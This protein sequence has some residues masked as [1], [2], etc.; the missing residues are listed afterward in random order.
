MAG[1]RRSRGRRREGDPQ[2]RNAGIQGLRICRSAYRRRNGGHHPPFRPRTPGRPAAPGQPRATAQRQGRAACSAA[3]RRRRAH[4]RAAHAAQTRPQTAP[5]QGPG[6]DSAER[7]RSR[8]GQGPVVSRGR[9]GRIFEAR[10]WFHTCEGQAHRLSLYPPSLQSFIIGSVRALVG[11]MRFVCLWR[12]VAAGM[13]CA[14]ALA[15]G[16]QDSEFNVNNQYT[17]ET[18]VVTGDGWST[19][20]GADRSGKISSPLR[21]DI[22]AIIGEK[23]NPATLDDL[24]RRLRKEFHARAVEHRIFRGKVPDSVQVVFEVQARPARFDVAIPKFLYQA[25]QG[26]SGAV[27]GTAIVKHN[28]LTVGLVSDGDELA[29]RYSGIT[30]WYQNSRAGSDRV[31]FGVEYGT[32][33]EEW[34]GSTLAALPASRPQME[35]PAWP[36]ESDLYRSRQFVE[37]EVTFQVSRPL[38][39]SVGASFE[40][41]EDQYPAVHTQTANAATAALRYHQRREGS[42]SLEDFDAGYDVRLASRALAGD[43]VYARH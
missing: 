1:R 28:G 4:D 3:G 34:N 24:G 43:L 9:F 6:A 30:A 10:L 14:G 33:H 27:E 38:S 2:P 5:R 13:L 31:R 26:W 22:L 19:D 35:P 11:R 37:P 12:M 8:T 20:V 7:V 42:D 16:T 32:Y 41:L 15:A 36:A 29:E 17:V 39:L 40:S 18:V 25:R 23:L 21:K